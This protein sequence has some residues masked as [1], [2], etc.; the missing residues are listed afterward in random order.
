MTNF[1]RWPEKWRWRV[2][3]SEELE[4]LRDELQ[5]QRDELKTQ[6]EIS[7]D[8]ARREAALSATLEETQQKI[9]TLTRFASEYEKAVNGVRAFILKF[10][11]LLFEIGEVTGPSEAASSLVIGDKPPAD[12]LATLIN[13]SEPL[14]GARSF[15]YIL[16]FLAAPRPFPLSWPKDAPPLKIIDVGSQELDSEDDM[17]AP[18]RAV[19][20]VEIVGFDPFMPVSDD[21]DPHLRSFDVTRKD[22]SKIKTYPILIG[23]GSEVTF[24]I[25]RYDATSSTL[26]T[27]HDITK[28]FGLLDLALETV[29]SRKLKSYRLDD[30]LPIEGPGARVDLLKID[31]QGAA[32]QL[33]ANARKVLDNT[34]VCHV[35]AE[36]A[37]IYLG[38]KLFADIDI[39]LRSA[40]FCFVDFFSL[41]RQRYVC[42]DASV[43]RA[44][45]RGR[46][47]WGDC[48]Y[49]RKFDEEGALSAEELFRAASIMHICYNKQDLSAELLRRLDD[50][51]GTDLLRRYIAFSSA[52][53]GTTEA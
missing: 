20:P 13:L 22:G 2:V 17:H 48:I 15:Q 44:F 5:T 38:Q 21:A 43:E 45:H 10:Q 30:V 23:D 41:G 46:T 35:E 6:R 49:I 11:S 36:F 42:F 7:A 28:P 19:I 9:G 29:D 16:P 40:G 25:N 14:H 32:Y 53:N 37:P 4:K 3:R 50:I 39:L 34:L 27:N 12:V 33:I 8:L 1:F 52:A 47:L 51:E 26:P 31:V 24:N 18:L